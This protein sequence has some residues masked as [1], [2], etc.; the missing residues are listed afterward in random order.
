M[1]NVFMNNLSKDA[2]TFISM[3]TDSHRNT[4][5]ELY[6]HLRNR[7]GRENKGISARL[8]FKKGFKR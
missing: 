8:A 4:L 7:Y 1:A 2:R 5:D 3:K 6:S